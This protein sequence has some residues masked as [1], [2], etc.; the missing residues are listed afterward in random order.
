MSGGS[1]LIKA[2]LRTIR[3]VNP[4]TQKN[5]FKIHRYA[6]T[7]NKWFDESE[8]KYVVFNPQSMTW[9]TDSKKYKLLAMMMKLTEQSDYE[10]QSLSLQMIS[11]SEEV[12]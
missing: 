12:E 10:R 7:F 9:K 8:Q 1:I 4:G 3:R 5:P 11:G 2:N 6:G